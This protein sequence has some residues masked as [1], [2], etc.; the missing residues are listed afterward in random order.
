MEEWDFRKEGRKGKDEQSFHREVI[1]HTLNNDWNVW[2]MRRG[3][4]KMISKRSIINDV[5]S[6]AKNGVFFINSL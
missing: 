4:T 3:D 2:E 5:S 6:Y 1:L